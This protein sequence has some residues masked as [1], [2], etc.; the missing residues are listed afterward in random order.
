MR[1]LCLLLGALVFLVASPAMA[2]DSDLDC[3]DFDSQAEAQAE[4]ESDPSDP[5]GLDADNDGEA[6]EEFDYGDDG[7]SDDGEE[8]G[9]CHVPTGNPENVK[10]ISAAEPSFDSHVEGH[11][12]DFP[13]GSEEECVPPGGDDA[14][15]DATGDQYGDDVADDD[16]A[17]VVNDTIPD[18]PLPNTGGLPLGGAAL[19]GVALVVVGGSVLRHGFKRD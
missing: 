10:F 6:C 11:E 17:D 1:R 12:G 13:V 19:L 18:K 4:L 9:I 3:A 15:D 8:G 14:A 16:A 2:Q 7:D 5:N